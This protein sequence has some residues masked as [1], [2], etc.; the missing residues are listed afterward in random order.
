MARGD[1]VIAISEYVAEHV[2][3]NYPRLSSHVTVI[4]E[5]IDTTYFDP[6]EISVEAI[7][8]LRAKWEIPTGSKVI[9]L[10]GRLTRWKGQKVLIKALRQ[11]DT[12]NLF[13]V[14]LGDSQ[15]REGYYQELMSQAKDLPVK[16]I[17]DYH[18]MPTAYALADV[19]LSC[20]T[21][22]EAFGRITAEALA[23]GRPYI[24]TDHGATPEMCIH[25]KTG[26]LVP[27]GNAE[28]L[29]AMIRY[30]LSLHDGKRNALSANARQHICQNFSLDQMVNRTLALYKAAL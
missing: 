27:F 23:M 16:F 4:H 8:A 14:I 13:G 18:D 3:Q 12:S 11:M 10:P 25:G 6:A 17:D 5:G 21:D 2:R 9:L 19:V 22:P 30:V 7:D 28:T 26:F 20:S 15:G 24:G 29:A 1:R